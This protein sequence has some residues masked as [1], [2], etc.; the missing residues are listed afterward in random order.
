MQIK[1]NPNKD[2]RRWSLIFFQIGMVIVLLIS[3][4]FI[5]RRTYDK[6]DEVEEVQI[7]KY[8]DLE[9]EDVIVTETPRTNT[10][11]PPPPPKAPDILNIVEDD[12]EIEEDEVE[13]VED[14]EVPKVEVADISEIQSAPDEGEPEEIESVPFAAIQDVPIFPG[15]EK[16][17][18]NEKRK[19]CM[20]DAVQ[21]F[22]NRRFNT[23]LAADLGMSGVT[24][25][26]VQFTVNEH[27]DVVDVMARATEPQL[28]DEAIRVVSML[29]SMQPG[30]QRGRAV[31]VIYQLPIMFQVN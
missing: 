22:V 21:R 4:I 29:P 11:P 1:K 17:K 19:K 5:E 10:P 24:R 23:D 20:S 13:T 2:L 8:T 27:G 31:R 9:P 12:E 25:I 26:N 15:C 7:V 6:V 16:F 14:I 28:E 3:W 18:D 30:K